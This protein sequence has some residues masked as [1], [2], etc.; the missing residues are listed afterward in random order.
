[1]KVRVKVTMPMELN[2]EQKELLKR[3]ASSRG[4][5]DHVRKHLE[6]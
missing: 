2:A 5:A 4:E 1:M 6:R 3:F